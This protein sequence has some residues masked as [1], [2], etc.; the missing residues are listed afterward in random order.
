MRF[1]CT[2]QY[3]DEIESDPLKVKVLTNGKILFSLYK[4]G[5]D[6]DFAKISVNGCRT[7]QAASFWWS[8]SNNQTSYCKTTGQEGDLLHL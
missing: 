1:N 3:A 2:L 5:F 4:N 7:W 8:V 6:L